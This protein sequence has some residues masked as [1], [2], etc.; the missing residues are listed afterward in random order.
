MKDLKQ[1]KVK[2][3]LI[4]V[5]RK[6]WMRESELRMAQRGDYL[7]CMTLI[8]PSKF[9]SQRV[10][11]FAKKLDL[12]SAIW[13]ISDFS[14][15]ELKQEI[16]KHW[17]G[18]ADLKTDQIK[19]GN[20][21]MTVLERINKMFLQQGSKVLGIAPQFQEY[22]T[23]VII[24][25]AEYK[26][27]PLLPEENFRFNIDRLLCEITKDYSLIYIDNPNNPTGQVVSLADI[28]EILK[29][30]ER[31][32]VVVILDEAELEYVGE[33]NSA[34]QLLGKWDNLIVTHS[35]TKAY[36][37]AALRVGYGILSEGLSGYYDKVALPF[38]IPAVASYLCK[39]AL[40]DQDFI[41]ILKQKI[42]STKEKL[43]T[44]LREQDYLISETH[45]S[46]P[47]FLL[48]SK[49]K[50]I[51]LKEYLLTKGII[52]VSGGDFNNVEKNYVRILIP[53]EADNF[54]ERLSN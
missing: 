37:L 53:P 51:D 27:V 13:D 24:S 48:G 44:G 45:P 41:Q 11:Q 10:S 8:E 22:V 33:E 5:S 39:E 9:V 26:G 12:A 36:G 29:E 15:K 30:A 46:S 1:L 6:S 40:L 49:S 2:P 47:F 38:P 32:E 21:S 54:L 7:N 42:R 3:Y 16:C 19:L 28:E 17:S 50:D 4:G 31:K 25:G 20:G 34:I 35:F 23:E 18:F 52:T 43:I 14:Y